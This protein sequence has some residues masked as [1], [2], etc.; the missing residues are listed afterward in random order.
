MALGKELDEY[1]FNVSADRKAFNFYNVSI[2]KS[3]LVSIRTRLEPDTDALMHMLPLS[4]V[5]RQLVRVI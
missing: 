2:L 5:P 1:S 4:A 3:T